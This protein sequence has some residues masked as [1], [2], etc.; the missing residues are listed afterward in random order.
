MKTL[1]KWTCIIC[2]TALFGI[3]L[4]GGLIEHS[5]LALDDELEMSAMKTDKAQINVLTDVTW[6]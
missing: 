2:S 5:A 1:K 4:F 3:L 6:S